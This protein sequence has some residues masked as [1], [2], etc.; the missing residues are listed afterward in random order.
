[1]HLLRLVIGILFLTVSASC[2]TPPMAI[3]LINYRGYEIEREF[4]P[5]IESFER[6][7]G[8]KVELRINFARTDDDIMLDIDGAVAYCWIVYPQHIRVD[9]NWWMRNPSKWRREELIYHELGHCVLFRM[10]TQKKKD[11]RFVS[12]MNNRLFADHI[13]YILFK[14]EYIKELCGKELTPKE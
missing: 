3:D 9:Y 4:L 13:Q 10:H 5:Y 12:I 7:C 6:D 2:A 8:K 1:M 11:G 14:E